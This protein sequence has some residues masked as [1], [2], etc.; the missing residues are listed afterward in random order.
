MSPEDL[1]LGDRPSDT[2]P[3]ARRRVLGELLGLWL[4][5]LLLIRAAVS[6][7]AAMGLPDWVLAAVPF[8]FIYAPVAL[9]RYRGVDSYAYRLSIPAFRDLRAWREALV[10]A[11][12]LFGIIAAPWAIGYHLYQSLL[13]GLSP[14]WRLPAEPLTLVAYQVFF[15]AIPEEFFYRGYIQ[16]RLNEVFPRTFLLFGIP[17]GHALW[18]TALLFAFGHSLVIVRWWHFAIFFPGLL[19]GLLRERSG[20]VLAGAFFHALCNIAVVTLD[21]AYGII[22]P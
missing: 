6:L 16:T 5:T 19:F 7:Q 2:S 15:V 10:D 13:F 1:P 17:F 20:G 11:L 21:T 18:I 3:A 12:A 8:L 14:S 22:P 4:V 9:C